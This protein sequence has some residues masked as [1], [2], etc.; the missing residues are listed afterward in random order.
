MTHRAYNSH[1]HHATG[2]L[3]ILM[4]MIQ[5]CNGNSTQQGTEETSTQGKSLQ[6]R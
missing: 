5:K 1:L 4:N 3:V 2:L 6:E